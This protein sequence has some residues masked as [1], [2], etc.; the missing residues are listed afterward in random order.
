MTLNQQ[1]KVLAQEAAQYGI[2][3][4]VIDRAIAPVLQSIAQQLNHLEYYIWQNV[5]EE[6]VISVIQNRQSSDVAKKVIYGFATVQDAKNLARNSSP[7]SIAIALPIIQILFRLFS[8]Q[9][10]DSIIL[11]DEPGNTTQGTEI[12]RLD[13]QQSIQKQ[14]IQLKTTPPDIA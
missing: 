5:R 13:L 12:K 1:I 2:S 6:W 11:F 9:Q 8:L 7:D 3:P 4:V 14:L 10:I